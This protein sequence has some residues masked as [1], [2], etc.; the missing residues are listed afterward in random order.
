EVGLSLH[1][2]RSAASAAAV[3]HALGPGAALHHH[4]NGAPG[5][6]GARVS[7]SHGAGLT[8]AVAHRQ[9]LIGCDV[10]G[11]DGVDAKA[12]PVLLG[13]QRW[14]FARDLAAAAG[15][16]TV[17]ACVMVWTAAECLYKIGCRAW[18]FALHQVDIGDTPHCGPQL[19]LKGEALAVAVGLLRVAGQPADV[20]V[21][22][23]LGAASI[24]LD[25]QRQDAPGEPVPAD[26]V[27]G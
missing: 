2:E 5:V 11:L 26:V 18:P 25:E 12:W 21:G 6:R 22:V 3:R 14:A 7:V 23:A 15:W 17:V 20:A 13:E 1:S 10:Q 16:S 8:L 24:D 4:A 19:V 9:R 27:S